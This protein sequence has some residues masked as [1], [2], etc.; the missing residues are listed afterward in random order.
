M[1]RSPRDAEGH[2]IV[3]RAANNPDATG[4]RAAN[5]ATI[6]ADPPWDHS[7]GTGASY[8]SRGRRDCSLPYPTMTVA[9]I[10]S[11]P[12]GEMAAKD[13]SLFLWTTNRF[14]DAAFDIEQAWG[15]RHVS[16]LVWCKQRGLGSGGVFYSNVEFVLYAKRG[17]V[18]APARINSRWFQ[19]SRSQHSAKP[20]AFL[21]LVEQVASGPYLELF[22]RRNRL[23]WSTW[24]NEA[25]EHIEVAS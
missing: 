8:S 16:T 2:A 17:T 23:G 9:E 3:T 21:D 13:A 1:E 12:V 18:P 20:E 4:T 7:D 5:F 10:A 14:L 25:L 22:A 6:V 24:G 19:W 11:L 15:F